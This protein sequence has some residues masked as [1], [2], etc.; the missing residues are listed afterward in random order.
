MPESARADLDRIANQGHRAAQLTRQI[1]DFSRQSV[2]KLYPL[3]LKSYLNE[4]L[5]FLERTI[6]ETVQIRFAYN[7]LDYTINADPASLQHVI[8]NLAVNARD[9]MPR[10]GTLSFDLSR[11]R[12]VLDEPPP[13]PDMPGGEWVKLTVSDTG[14]GIAPEVLSHIFEPF[15]TTKE[16]GKG[17]G[18]GLAQVYGIVTQHYGY[19]TVDSRPGQG[20][21]F[22][23]YFPALVAQA[24]VPTKVNENTPLGQGETILLVEDDQMVRDVTL[25]MLESLSYRVL[26][27]QDGSEALTLYHNQADEIALVLTDAL[28]PRMDGFALAAALQTAAPELKVILMSGYAGLPEAASE[29]PQNVITQL[30]KPMNLHQLAQALREALS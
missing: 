14:S 27:A 23:L 8:T 2:M 19:I 26:T 7:P 17:T 3:D 22:S 20:A 18:L 1:L 4:I 13:C 12:L 6:P 21:S 11:I 30:Q 24:A 10:G 16:I 9:A 29:L 28:M 5:K 25:H 15:F